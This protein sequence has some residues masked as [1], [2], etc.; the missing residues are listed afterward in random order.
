[1]AQFMQ[2]V[3]EKMKNMF[4]KNYKSVVFAVAFVFY[5][6]ISFAQIPEDI[7]VSLKTGNAS[8]LSKFFNK[9]IELV[10]ID[11]DDVFSKSQAEQI[12]SNF[13]KNHEAKRFDIIHEGGKEGSSYGIGNLTTENGSFRVYFLLKN[14]NGKLYIHQLRIEKQ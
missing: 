10:V 8:S 9:N 3:I 13:F 2:M 14:N 4:L 7:I 6:I 1:M 11:K 5:S 12:V